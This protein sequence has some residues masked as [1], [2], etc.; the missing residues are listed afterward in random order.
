MAE[1][2]KMEQVEQIREKTGCTYEEAKNAL[3]AANGDVLDAIIALEKA[4]K[5]KTGATATASTNPISGDKP[6]DGPIISDDMKQAQADYQA[7]TS[8]SSFKKDLNNLW[9]LIKGLFDKSLEVKLVGMRNGEV[10]FT[11]PVI[12]LIL[13]L[14]F[15][16]STLWLL[17]LGL[18]FG[19]RY[20]FVGVKKTTFEVDVNDAMEKAAN[21][22]DELKEDLKKNE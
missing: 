6:Q 7:S 15:W 9:E 22:V 19:F 5:V 12:V 16:G 3:D 20:H 10:V 1:T 11:L 4:G 14:L 2:N 21:K 17:I 18:F 13:G 8:A